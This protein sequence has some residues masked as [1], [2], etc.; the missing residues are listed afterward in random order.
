VADDRDKSL[1]VLPAQD[2]VD[3]GWGGSKER[4]VYKATGKPDGLFVNKNR[5]TGMAS[6][7]GKYASAYA[8]G[9][10]MLSDY[11][12][13]FADS[14]ATKAVEAYE[15]GKKFPGVCQSVPAL[16][17]KYFEENDWTDDM[18]LAAMQLY[19]ISYESKY[20]DEAAAY[21]RMQPVSPWIFSKTAK[22]YQW[23]PFTNYGH[24]LLANLEQP[25]LR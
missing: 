10:A 6:I 21:A 14:L 12:P 15:L 4:P 7:A 11:Y 9:A 17:S 8:L 18:E 3:Y 19:Y 22:Y 23:Y 2:T 5:T 1:G 16:K 24:F 20:M 25:N 13:V